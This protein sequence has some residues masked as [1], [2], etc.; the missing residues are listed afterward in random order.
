MKL[1]KK[2]QI[3]INDIINYCKSNHNKDKEKYFDKYICIFNDNLVFDDNIII[4]IK[5]NFKVG[6]VGSYDYDTKPNNIQYIISVL[7][8]ANYKIKYDEMDNVYILTN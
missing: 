4:E 8:K 6:N 1:N 3:I 7:K 5:N 2:Q